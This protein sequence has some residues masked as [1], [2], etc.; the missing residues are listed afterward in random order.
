MQRCIVDYS[1]EG[2][3]DNGENIF[4]YSFRSYGVFA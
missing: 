1:D 2:E 4:F 3:N